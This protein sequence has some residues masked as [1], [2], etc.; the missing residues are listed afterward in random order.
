MAEC[1]HRGEGGVK[2]PRKSV[3]VVYEQSLM[4]SLQ[5]P[6]RGGHTHTHVWDNLEISFSLPLFSASSL[7][8]LFFS[9]LAVFVST[10]HIEGLQ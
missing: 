5:T 3:H 1:P 4:D 7:A 6:Y 2:N 9:F 10:L 8:F